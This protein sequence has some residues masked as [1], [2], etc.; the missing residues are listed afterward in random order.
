[1]DVDNE[2]LMAFMVEKL[3]GEDSVMLEFRENRIWEA[4][5]SG[6]NLGQLFDEAKDE[7]WIEHF[8]RLKV[9]GLV[10]IVER[11]SNGS[12]PRQAAAIALAAQKP[13][14]RARMSPE[15]KAVLRE[16]IL[17]HLRSHPWTGVGEISKAVGRDT[18]RLGIH[19]RQMRR[20]GILEGKGENRLTTYAVK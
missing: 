18:R 19:L 11:N 6:K 14:R 16:S 4:A 5:V 3:G 15:E 8:R 1:M 13:E 12:K 17:A 2:A 9:S 7:G 10:K 20:E